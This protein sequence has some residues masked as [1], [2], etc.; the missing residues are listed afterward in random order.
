MPDLLT[1]LH[2]ISRVDAEHAGVQLVPIESQQ[3]KRPVFAI[4]SVEDVLES[5][6]SKPDHATLGRA[7]RWLNKTGSHN[8][9]FN[10]K[11]PGPKAA[12]IVFTL[13]NDIVPDYWETLRD[14][15]SQE[16]ILLAQCLRSVAGIGAITASLR[17]LL[18][19][20]KDNQ[21]PAQTTLAS[22]T[23]PVDIL[24]NVLDTALAKE[25]FITVVWYDIKAYCVQPYQRSLQWKELC[26]L[27]ASGKVLSIA[28]EANLTLRELTP[29]I[30]EWCWV[31]DG[32]QYAMW[33]GRCMQHT[34]KAMKDDDA[35]GERALSQ[36]LSKGLS[37]G[38]PGTISDFSCLPPWLIVLI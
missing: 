22:K 37:L 9:G 30:K 13:V 18:A 32:S 6:R 14:E 20:L 28:S 34:L 26:S 29:S 10:I 36:L 12:Q 33:L 15:S 16:K 25:D 8:D 19:L 27:V 3:K 7:L 21:K 11:K 1:T 38:Y 5:L 17:L 35:E 2:T 4:K 24:L 31:G 23:Q